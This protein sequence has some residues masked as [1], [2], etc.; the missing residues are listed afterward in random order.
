VVTAT[1][2]LFIRFSA[3]RQTACPEEAM[4]IAHSGKFLTAIGR[5]GWVSHGEKPSWLDLPLREATKP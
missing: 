5:S 1:L 3:S 2:V 4:E